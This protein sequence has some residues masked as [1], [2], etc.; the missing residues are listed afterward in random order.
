MNI[1]SP[2]FDALPPQRLTSKA[3]GGGLQRAACM[4]EARTPR[5]AVVICTLVL[6]F[7]SRLPAAEAESLDEHLAPLRPF[8]GKTWKGEFKNSTPEKPRFDISRWERALNGKAVRVV[9]SVN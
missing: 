5:L 7:A 2:S 1:F 4:R 8:L 9:H 6:A 3:R